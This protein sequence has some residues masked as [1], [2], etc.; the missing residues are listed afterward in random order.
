[1][2]TAEDWSESAD[3]A[4][5]IGDPDL[6]RVRALVQSDPAPPELIAALSTH[7][8]RPGADVELRQKQTDALRDLFDLGG[9]VGSMPTGE[10]K[11]LVSL[12]APTLLGAERPVLILPANCR[13]KTRTEFAEYLA[14]GWHVRLPTLLSYSELS[15]QSRERKLLELQPDLIMLDEADEARNIDGTGFG[16]RIRRALATLSPRPRVAILSATLIGDDLLEYWELL[17]WALQ[18]KAP[19]PLHKAAAE[20]WASATNRVVK[21]ELRRKEPGALDTLPGGFHAW[22]R[23]RRGVV[24][25]RGEIC[26]SAI[27][28]TTWVPPISHE[29]RQVINACA[30]TSKRPDGERVT[31]WELPDLLCCLAQG[32][33]Q[34]WDPMPPRWWLDPRRSYLDFERAIL[35]A[36]IEGFDTPAQIRDALDARPKRHI[37]ELGNDADL[38][39]AALANWRA[40]KDRFKPNAVPVW[41]TGEIMDAVATHAGSRAGQIVWVKH[42]APGHELARRGL[43]YFGADTQPHQH[44]PGAPMV[45]SIKAH[46]R[47]KNL[48]AW[49][50]ALVMHPMAKARL[51]EQLIS[52]EHRPGQKADTIFVEVIAGVEYHGQVLER[53]LKQAQADSDASGVPH[54]MVLA[55]WT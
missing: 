28:I 50:R 13:D 37:P 10:G 2:H 27:E 8:S 16:R 14:D 36:Q 44:T 33:Y 22:L 49:W 34:V 15:L 1:M 39:R 6:V 31:D 12:L 48:Q 9:C 11:T 24:S 4:C 19:V 35:D 45:C 51:W 53:V 21:G 38:V 54:K 3:V 30:I 26:P 29:L 5:E 55:K 41:I 20:R 43:P 18:D 32:F 25:G 17:L 42:K 47:G 46:G 7:L 23:S 40:V 52:R